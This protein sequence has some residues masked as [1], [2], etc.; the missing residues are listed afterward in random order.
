M[1]L[2]K[3]LII[4]LLSMLQLVG[5]GQRTNYSR[6]QSQ[7]EE[8]SS[9]QE[10]Q[11]SSSEQEP[12]DLPSKVTIWHYYGNLLMD[13]SNLENVTKT[14]GDNSNIE[15]DLVHKAG[16]SSELIKYVD[17]AIPAG[18]CPDIISIATTQ[19][20][21]VNDL[22]RTDYQ[23]KD[24]IVEGITNYFIPLDNDDSNFIVENYD[25]KAYS[26]VVYQN[27]IYGFPVYIWDTMIFSNDTNEYDVPAKLYVYFFLMKAKLQSKVGTSY[28]SAIKDYI[29]DVCNYYLDN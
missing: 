3:A 28:I 8:Q 14:I 25:S 5:C 18:K 22:E 19:L 24:N 13:A 12:K 10:A 9:S 2:K 20:V 6:S 1:T 29:K 7:Q 27:R 16:T 15:V 23:P 26:S 4:P 21:N 17:N 11:E